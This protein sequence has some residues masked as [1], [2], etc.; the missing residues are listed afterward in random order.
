[1]GK[2]I[3]ALLALHNRGTTIPGKVVDDFKVGGWFSYVAPIKFVS[4]REDIKSP[5]RTLADS[6]AT[7]FQD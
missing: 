3:S 1:M 7:L 2:G 5:S 6:G 4:L